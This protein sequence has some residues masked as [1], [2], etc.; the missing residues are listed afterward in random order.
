[1]LHKS[2]AF[3]FLLT[4]IFIVSRFESSGGEVTPNVERP[5]KAAMPAFVPAFRQSA[6]A[7]I[8]FIGHAGGE[9]KTIGSTAFGLCLS[10]DGHSLLYSQYDQL[11]ADLMLV[12]NFH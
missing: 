7:L 4:R 10:P 6:G 1:M 9:P 11:A 8:R 2:S 12:E 5:F 3:Y